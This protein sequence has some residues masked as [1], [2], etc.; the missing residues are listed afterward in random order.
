MPR[1]AAD[2]QHTRF[3]AGELSNRLVDALGYPSKIQ[4]SEYRIAPNIIV[5]PLALGSAPQIGNVPVTNSLVDLTIESFS[6][7]MKHVAVTF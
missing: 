5:K 4:L 1:A 3:V 2:L 6:F 7:E